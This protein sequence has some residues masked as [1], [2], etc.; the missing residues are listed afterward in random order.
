MFSTNAYIC[1]SAKKWCFKTHHLDMYSY[2][3]YGVS[4]DCRGDKPA[5]GGCVRVCMEFER[6]RGDMF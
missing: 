5:P 1:S 2:V 6:G 3:Y 4:A